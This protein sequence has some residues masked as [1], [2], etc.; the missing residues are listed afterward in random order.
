M[1]NQQ[2]QATEV[3]IMQNKY[4]YIAGILLALMTSQIGYAQ[5][6]ISGGVAACPLRKATA[7]LAF[8]AIAAKY[9]SSFV[10]MCVGAIGPGNGITPAYSVTKCY[11]ET[12]L[13]SHHTPTSQTLFGIGSITKTMTATLLALRVNEGSVSLNDPVDTLLPSLY[14]IPKIT[15]LQLAD[16]ESGLTKNPPNPYPNPANETE[17]YTDLQTCVG[18]PGCWKGVNRYSYSNFAYGVLGNALANHDGGLRWSLD[19]FYYVMGPLGLF[20][21]KAPDDYDPLDFQSRRAHGYSRAGSAWIVSQTTSTP[22]GVAPAGGLWSTPDDMLIWLGHAMGNLHSDNN[23]DAALQK[24][25]ECR[26]RWG[27][28]SNCSSVQKCGRCTG[29]AWTEDIDECTGG[30]RI[31]K[32]GAVPGFKSWIGFDQNTGRGVF[33][34]FNSGGLDGTPV[35]EELLEIL[36]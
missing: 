36:P 2:S 20:D 19:N 17:L 35:G 18:A 1:S 33:V 34:L 31:S 22:F 30:V 13:G 8:D 16:M 14:Q 28:N 11:G 5:K 6:K 10:G 7:A 27:N 3:S 4:R 32:S 21:T 25:M 23:V 29:L 12:R 9:S 24:T 15:L 26:A